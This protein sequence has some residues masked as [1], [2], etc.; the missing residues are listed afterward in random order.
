MR[1]SRYTEEQITSVIKASEHGKKVKLIC[2]E[3]SISEATFYSWKKKFG[4]LS[5][6]EGRKI[7]ALEDQ[8]H[9]MA[10]ELQQLTADKEMLQSV[11]KNFFTTSD[12]RRA[13]NYLQN[14]YEIGTRRSCRL[15]DISR[16][17]YHYPQGGGHT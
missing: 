1:K 2:D 15:L 10:R 11:V 7:K 9:A 16:S 8:L 3:L 6:E 14:T 4:G 12:K 5:S 13:V 17:V